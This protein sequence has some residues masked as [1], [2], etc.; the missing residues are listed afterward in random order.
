MRTFVRFGPI[1]GPTSLGLVALV[2]ACNTDSPQEPE[3]VARATEAVTQ[4]RPCQVP[5]TPGVPCSRVGRSITIPIP[6]GTGRDQVAVFASHAL[7]INDR[8]RIEAM[9][10]QPAPIV[11]LGEVETIIGADAVLGGLQSVAS[12]FLRERATVSGPLQTTGTITA[13]NGVTISGPVSEG[14]ELLE[15]LDDLSW[16]VFAP[17]EA[18][19]A[20]H[21]EPGEEVTLEP[22]VYGALR[23]APR[24]KVHLRSGR[25]GFDAFTLESDGEVRFSGPEPVLL[26]VFE[27]FTHRGRWVAAQ[28]DMPPVLVSYVGRAPAWVEAA[29]HGT[30]VAP[31]AKVELRAAGGQAHRG[32][33]FG[34]E[35]EIHGDARVIQVPFPWEALDEA[36]EDAIGEPE[37]GTYPT[38]T[39]PVPPLSGSPTSDRVR[40]FLD[41]YYKA[42]KGD[43]PD[44]VEEVASVQGDDVIA[45]ELIAE[46][47]R[48][49]VEDPLRASM[50][51]SILGEL[52][53]PAG[54]QFFIELLEEPL[55][56]RVGMLPKHGSDA[57]SL[58]LSYQRKAVHGLGVMPTVTARAKLRE[59]ASAH[60]DRGLRMEVVRAYVFEQP[61][62]VKAELTLRP[63]EEFF[64]D[65]FENRDVHEDGGSFDAQ[66]DAYRAKYPDHVDPPE[67]L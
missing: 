35:V 1:I 63:G 3:P 62:A 33:F 16:P 5:T 21:L 57:R 7:K 6:E 46:F 36:T 43:L 49:R 28:G 24:A 64:V 15:E 19:P 11:G 13:Q 8:V 48:L 51:L 47:Q 9:G 12:V 25:Y 58:Q 38:S 26:D 39:G 27:S 41:W 52:R 45:A 44:I 67:E 40:V 17:N 20:I 53:A 31:E 37:A 32:S 42:V 56:D 18:R 65:R 14:H 23:I 54:E 55:P 59:H 4:E 60:P 50:V 22:G 2:V 29:F 66:L 10:G 30:L 61:E 34:Y